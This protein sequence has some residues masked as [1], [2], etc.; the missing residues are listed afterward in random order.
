M[1]LFES[2]ILKK[3]SA[4]RELPN[5]D[6]FILPEGRDISFFIDIYK[7]GEQFLE[8]SGELPITKTQ[9]AF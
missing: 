4:Y 6:R 7:E 8:L 3:L 2:M 1:K 9:E 5:R